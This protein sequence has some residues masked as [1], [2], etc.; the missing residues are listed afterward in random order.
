M[1]LILNLAVGG[2]W[3]GRAGIDDAGFP[4]RLEIDYVRVYQTEGREG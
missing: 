3:A 4:A 1:Y 2:A